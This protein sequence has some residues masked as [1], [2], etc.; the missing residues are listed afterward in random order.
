MQNFWWNQKYY[1]GK[2]A[3]DSY[4]LHKLEEVTDGLTDANTALSAAQ[5]ALNDLLQANSGLLSEHTDLLS[6]LTEIAQALSIEMEELTAL[7][8]DAASELYSLQQAEQ[9]LSSALSN[10]V[11]A[12]EEL[13]QTVGEIQDSMGDPEN[14]ILDGD[15]SDF[16]LYVAGDVG[17]P[18]FFFGTNNN[19]SGTI[20]NED[21]S[22]FS[23]GSGRHTLWGNVKN[24]ELY[25]GNFNMNLSAAPS[26]TDLS[27]NNSTINLAFPSEPTLKSIQLM[28][29]QPKT[30]SM[31]LDLRN[32]TELKSI[33]LTS[34]SHTVLFPELAHRTFTDASGLRGVCIDNTM[35]TEEMLRKLLPTRTAAY[36]GNLL[37]IGPS[38]LT[39]TAFLAERHWKLEVQG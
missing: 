2:N 12:R 19:L 5:S 14:V 10:E 15:L 21:R 17:T 39:N 22:Q 4:R 37:V 33:N 32:Q 25:G 6:N 30:T 7:Y 3:P 38:N 20:L 1:H 28:S 8:D 24:V 35:A 13:S 18:V 9:D 27:V 34:V 11:T 29:S 36:P 23:G 26:L 16:M 31:P